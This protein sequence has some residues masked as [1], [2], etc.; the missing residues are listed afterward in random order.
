MEGLKKL[1]VKMDMSQED[2]TE[3]Q[4]FQSFKSFILLRKSTV[5]LLKAIQ[6]WQQTFT[7]LKRPQ[8][9]EKDYLVGMIND[10]DYF[11]NSKARK[12]LNFM[13]G[14]GNPLLLPRSV[15]VNAGK[16]EPPKVI[17]K[18][19][20]DLIFMYVNADRDE[21]RNSYQVF[22][23]SLSP[24]Q[25][26][27]LYSAS[28]WLTGEAWMPYVDIKGILR[29]VTGLGATSSTAQRNTTLSSTSSS[30]SRQLDH[31]SST[32]SDGVEEVALVE[33]KLTL[34]DIKK[35]GEDEDSHSNAAEDRHD[36]I[37]ESFASDGGEVNSS[38]PVSS[39]ENPLSPSRSGKTNANSSTRRRSSMV[40][41]EKAN[42]KYVKKSNSMKA[43]DSMKAIKEEKDEEP[44]EPAREKKVSTKAAT[45]VAR[46]QDDTLLSLDE[47][48]AKMKVSTGALKEWFESDMKDTFLSS[49]ENGKNR[50]KSPGSKRGAR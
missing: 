17:S 1:I 34:P 42:G 14:R 15:A 9:M 23:D 37:Q 4:L 32:S 28:A 50:L 40:S 46:Y 6:E 18:K 24:F 49:P 16:S 45:H 36:T 11:S 10:S 22:V 33:E 39:T 31:R 8:L 43:S 47:R 13:I 41:G 29:P 2:P 12:Y 35:S 27:K 30:S 5:A 21:I 26:K 25:Y 44:K 48:V 38:R 3:E 19:L 7:N 20:A